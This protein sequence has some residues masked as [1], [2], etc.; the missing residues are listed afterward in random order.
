MNGDSIREFM[1]WFKWVLVGILLL[2]VAGL[3]VFSILDRK[4]KNI[5]PIKFITVTGIF[6]ALAT[7]LYVLVPD[8]GL[9]FTPPWLKVHLDEIPIFLVG[10]MYGPLSAIMVTLVKTII[11]LPMSS[12][13]CVGEIG[14]FIF[15]MI[16]VIPAIMI[17]QRRRKLS[18]VFIGVGISTFAHV[19]FAMIAN[20]YIMIP[21]YSMLYGMSLE[22]IEGMCTAV[23]PIVQ[24]ENWIWLYALII[25]L[26]MNL[27]KNTIVVAVV[28]LLYKRLHILIERIADQINN[29]KD[30]ST[31]D[32]N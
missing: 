15:T 7:I 19:V 25:V 30:P 6:G 24:G 13:A 26:P 10:Y 4:K 11:K 8:F 18:S 29:K 21:F 1:G 14:D 9:G 16:F 20:V 17:Y 12:T 2:V 27:I 31:N 5:S 23:V 28:L 32:S 3:I 22:Q